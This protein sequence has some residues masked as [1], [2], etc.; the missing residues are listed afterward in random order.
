MKISLRCFA[1]VCVTLAAISTALAQK[2]TRIGYVYPAGG[3]QGQTVDIT[4]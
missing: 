1:F 3:Q 2:A 4:V